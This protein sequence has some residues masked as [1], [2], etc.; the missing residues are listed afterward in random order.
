MKKILSFFSF[1]FLLCFVFG[2]SNFAPKKSSD[3]QKIAAFLDYDGTSFSINTNAKVNE[4]IQLYKQALEKQIAYSKT[5]SS[6][7]KRQIQALIS[8]L[9]YLALSS[10]I[11]DIKGTG[12]SSKK[13]ED[14][15][16]NKAFMLVDA[17]SKGFLWNLVG[18]KNTSL[19]NF[20]ELLPGEETYFAGEAVINLSSSFEK[21]KQY[22]LNSSEAFKL[23]QPLVTYQLD[24]LIASSDGI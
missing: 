9:E 8:T 15:Y 24:Q 20:V 17:N 1:L 13:I 16:Y 4:T 10:G 22:S 23:L 12:F 14:F 21:L 18:K 19:G 6:L 2:C 11:A 7:S 3:F 5:I